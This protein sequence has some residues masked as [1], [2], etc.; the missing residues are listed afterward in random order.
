[1]RTLPHGFQRAT[2]W[3][4]LLGVLLFLQ[5]G[6]LFLAGQRYRHFTTKTPLPERHTLILGFMGGR[7]SWDDPRP[8]VARLAAKLRASSL[9]GVHIETVENRRRPLALQ[10][11]EQGFDQNQNGILEREEKVSGRLI[12]YGQS[13]GGAAVVKL[14][15]ELH[16]AE[17]PALL[18]VQVDSVG[19]G[20]ARI[21]ANVSCAANLFQQDGLVIRGEREIR[22]E[23]PSKTKIMGNFQYHYR[24]RKI[25]LSHVPWYKKIFR[26]AHTK[27][28]WDPEV[29]AK[30]EALILDALR[31]GCS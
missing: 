6:C 15:R 13:F 3:W 9:P 5:A 8:G 27:M 23:D 21:P 30:V 25:D 19:R 29:W 12:L 31:R 1:M 18:T 10:L 17:I 24:D 11:I 26:V 7:D 14:A 22:A 16:K 2:I 28:D 20:D 4:T